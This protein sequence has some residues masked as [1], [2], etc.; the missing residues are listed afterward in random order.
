MIEKTFCIIK[1]DA[2]ER[3]LVGLILAR[4]ALENLSIVGLLMLDLRRAQVERIYITH[5]GRPYWEPHLAFMMSG[6]CVGVELEGESAVE[7]LRTVVGATNPIEAAP[8]T[9]RHSYGTVLPRNV[10]HASDSVD[11]AR[12]ESA[13]FFER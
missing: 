8:G 4:I 10:V 12:R 11:S 6:P 7:R 3:N 1:P 5:I 2:I 13:I 9:L